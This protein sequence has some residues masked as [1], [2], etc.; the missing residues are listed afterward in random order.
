M[1][2][3]DSSEFLIIAVVALIAIGPK[4]LPGALRTAG[5]WV[6][7][8]RMLTREFQHSVDEMVRQAE[9]EELRDQAKKLAATNLQQEI[10]KTVD[11]D[12]ELYRAMNNAAFDQPAATASET[13][14]EA[15]ALAAPEEPM[16]PLEAPH[17]APQ[18]AGAEPAQPEE[19]KPAAAAHGPA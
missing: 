13:P 17:P 7:K 8:A 11:P 16:L 5:R 15:P 14:S 9:L 2:G 3:I 19:A 4:D 18:V 1:F 6:R 12:G 10:E